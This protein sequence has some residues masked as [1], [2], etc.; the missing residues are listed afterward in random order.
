MQSFSSA[1]SQSQGYFAAVS[2]SVLALSPSGTH[3]QILAVVKTVALVLLRVIF[4]HFGPRR[5]HKENCFL[6]IL[7]SR[8]TVSKASA[9]AG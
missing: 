8:R 1:A 9:E 3:D 7:L 4:V 2:Q 6:L 5:K